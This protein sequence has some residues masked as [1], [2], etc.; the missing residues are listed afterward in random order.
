M[1]PR[2][3]I[4]RLA[5]QSD[6][7]LLVLVATGDERAF[8]TL[9]RRYRPALLRYC[10]RLGL[11]EQGAEDVVQQ[12]LTKAWVALGSDSEVRELRP[13]LYRIVHNAAVNTLSRAGEPTR[14]LT[15]AHERAVANVSSIEPA[16]A[17]REAL[18][19]VADLPAMQ[20]D[21]VVLTAIQGRSHEE[22]AV[23]LG[24]SDGAVRGLLYRARANLRS[25]AAALTPGWLF[26]RLGALGSNVP[27][28][29][30]GAGDASLSGGMLGV[31]AV[32]TKLGV[33]AA[34]TG[35]LVA[36]V[37]GV[38]THAPSHGT[39]ASRGTGAE[40][41]SS[42]LRQDSPAGAGAGL[43]A[44]P[45]E[46][47]LDSRGNAGRR[48]EGRDDASKQH[49]ESSDDVGAAESHGGPASG[50]GSGDSGDD[51]Q[52]SSGEGSSSGATGES[53]EG[54]RH[55]GRG[56]GDDGSGSPG[57]PD[58]TV[59]V[60]QEPAVTPPA[61]DEEG[62]G[63]DQEAQDGLKPS[64]EDDSEAGEESRG[65]ASEGSRRGHEPSS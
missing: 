38:G 23:A 59:T 32:L 26:Q 57:G 53:V 65:G 43:L 30:A 63:A 6:R 22:T 60:V 19:Q 47:S 36:G 18:G 35:L 13:W 7:R 62:A 14:P 61:G 41:R 15:D 8:E 27:A 39:G 42:A 9:V 58:D 34:G 56:S 21:A 51:E 1:S 3:S 64:G 44:A 33:L 45:D 25:A 10:R 31:G 17:A 12:S 20:R 37:A 16:L 46:R 52:G 54:V 28:S 55:R 5:L 2:I 49:R 11:D 50:S 4:P 40:I 29:G 48:A 24:V